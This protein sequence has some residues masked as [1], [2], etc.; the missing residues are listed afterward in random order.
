MISNYNSINATIQNTTLYNA[1]HTLIK[2]FILFFIFI[3]DINRPFFSALSPSKE[4]RILSLVTE[5]GI[6][7]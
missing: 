3:F 4:M 2:Y 5:L 1:P 7:R 6:G